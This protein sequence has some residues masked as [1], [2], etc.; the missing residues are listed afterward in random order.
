MKMSVTKVLAQ[1]IVETNYDDLPKE[2]IHKAKLCILDSLGCALGGYE[3]KQGK[4]V[5]DLMRHLGGKPESTIVGDGEKISCVHAAFTN[6][7]LTNA[8]DFDDT[9]IGHPGMTVIPSAFAVGEKVDA[10][11]KDLMTAI[12]LG[13]DVSTRIGAAIRPSIQRRLVHGHASWQTFGAVVPAVKFLGLNELGVLD[14]MGIAGCNAPLPSGMKSAYNPEGPH[15]NKN[16]SGTSSEVGVMAA[17]L[18]QRGFRGPRNILDGETGFWRMCGSDRC[19]F[20]G[21]TDKL[22]EEYRIIRVSFKPYSACRLTHSAIEATLEVIHE[23]DISPDD[24]EKIIIKTY[25]PATSGSF[26]NAEPKNMPQAQFSTVYAI[27]VA[28]HRVPP[29]PK[30]FAKETLRN[31]SILKLAK[32]VKLFGDQEADEAFCKDPSNIMATA[33]VYVEGRAYNYRVEFP[34]GDPKKRLTKGEIE[35]KFRSLAFE[36]LGERKVMDIIDLVRN[37]EKLR[38]AGELTKLLSPK[39]SS[40]N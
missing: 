16:S 31:A 40:P 27:A 29:G 19:D 3:T 20:Q 8:L 23:H 26:M 4:I 2:V 22:G 10:S 14:A 32:K 18:A 30:W 36:S 15:M 13:Y 34:R 1:H 21:M 9:Y 39:T 35:E 17:L 28:V 38:R 5:V 33:K 24:I 7:A 25:S 37:L 6:T 12:V 11:G